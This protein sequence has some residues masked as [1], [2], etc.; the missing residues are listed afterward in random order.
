METIF[1]D[2]SGWFAL[3]SSQ[4]EHHKEIKN[5]LRENKLPFV[6]TNY[7]VAET[8][9][10]LMSRKNHFLAI[11]FLEK[12]EQ[13]PRVSV[14]HISP[15]QHQ[16]TIQFFK[17]HSDEEFSFIDCASFVVMKNLNCWKALAFDHH[18]LQAG[19][20]VVPLSISD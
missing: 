11:T 3:L 17:Q 19:F 9:N 15:S 4:D 12:I 5:Y 20:Q 8:V 18:F 7:V 14:H 16:E 10:L 6:T 1:V 2:T 13:S